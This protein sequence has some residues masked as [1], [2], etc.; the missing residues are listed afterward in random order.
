MSRGKQ[1]LLTLAVALAVAVP[2]KAVT[3]SG[4]VAA[5]DDRAPEPVSSLS[6]F[7]GP[8]GVELSWDL[9]SS[10]FVRQSPAG[11]DFTSG[12]T[13]VNVNDVA[14]YNVWRSENS[15]AFELAGWVEAGSIL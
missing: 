3:R 9:S 7:N 13:F 11:L 12:G 5:T 2:A 1:V 8:A 10:D 6:A 14:R 4:S 15:G